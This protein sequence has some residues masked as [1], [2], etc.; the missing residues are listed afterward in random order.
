VLEKIESTGNWMSVGYEGYAQDVRCGLDLLK[1]RPEV[2]ARRL[3]LLG[4]SEGGRIGSQVAVA[5]ADVAFLV[6]LA[7]PCVSAE[8]FILRHNESMLR[9]GNV[10]G[11]KP[12]KDLAGVRELVVLLRQT[13]DP[14]ERE[15]KVR[16]V[17]SR[18]KQSAA[19]TDQEVAMLSSPWARDYMTSD[20]TQYL[21]AL[22][23]PVLALWGAKDVLVEPEQSVAG[24][25][26]ALPGAD[27]SRL[28]IRVLP[29]LNHL[30]Q[31]CETGNPKEFFKIKET[32]NPSAL[33]VIVDWVREHA[34]AG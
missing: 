24:L 12:E 17:V 13:P 4:H 20:T 10:S 19:E 9:R 1:H 31:E 11:E 16:E 32:I 21:R 34:R 2:D 26:K 14:T 22:R 6:L 25:R 3:G 33:R 28:A 18:K 15:R 5:T 23:C 7:A 30:F 27:E 8:D 29:G